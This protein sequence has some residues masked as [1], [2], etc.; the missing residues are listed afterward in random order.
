M[1]WVIIPL[2]AGR[3]QH[4]RPSGQPYHIT[5]PL[6]GCAEITR[7]GSATRLKIRAYVMWKC[8]GHKRKILQLDRH[9]IESL[10]LDMHIDYL[11]AG[12]PYILNL[13]SLM[14]DDKPRS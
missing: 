4:E 6:N 2:A 3:S 12:Y 13:A 1:H 14:E 8:Q 9:L 11:N 7:E 5:N 10:S